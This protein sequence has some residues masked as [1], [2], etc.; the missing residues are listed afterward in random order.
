MQESVHEFDWSEIVPAIAGVLSFL[1]S[2]RESTSRIENK[3]NANI[4]PGPRSVRDIQC[5]EERFVNSA[6]FSPIYVWFEMGPLLFLFNLFG[7]Q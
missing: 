7:V 4:C 2:L 1:G 3:R 6:M 5:R